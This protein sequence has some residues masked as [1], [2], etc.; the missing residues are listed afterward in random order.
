[1]QVQRVERRSSQAACAYAQEWP[2][3]ELIEET[4]EAFPDKGIANVEEARVHSS[5]QITRLF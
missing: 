2:D 5:F 1:M 4:K 3:P